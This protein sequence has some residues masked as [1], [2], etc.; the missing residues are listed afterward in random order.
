MPQPPKTKE[1]VKGE[2]DF[3]MTL[4]DWQR[5]DHERNPIINMQVDPELKLY[6]FQY[7]DE[8][9]LKEVKPKLKN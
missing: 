7:L 2:I 4:P 5:A 9:F 6:A 8:L 1:E 3:L